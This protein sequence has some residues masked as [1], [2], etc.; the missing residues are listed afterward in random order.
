MASDRD[1]T[2][3]FLKM[4]LTC[5]ATVFSLMNSSAAIARFVF[6]VA[7]SARTS[8]SRRLSDPSGRRSG[9]PRE[10]LEIRASAQLLEHAAR[11]IELE[12]GTCIVPELAAGDPD[13]HS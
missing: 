11:R 2:R 6:P 7:T 8:F 12:L 1:E 3:S 10:A 5:R 4:L 9:E 13:Q